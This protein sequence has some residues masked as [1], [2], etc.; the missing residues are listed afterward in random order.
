MTSEAD[1]PLGG[2]TTTARVTGLT[3]PPAAKARLHDPGPRLIVPANAPLASA[4]RLSGFGAVGIAALTGTFVPARA[5][6]KVT[7]AAAVGVAVTVRAVFG[8]A[9]PAIAIAPLTDAPSA[10]ALTAIPVAL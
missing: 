8:A 2:G 6:V 10:G 5:I 3:P 9:V 1:S 4:A 7:G